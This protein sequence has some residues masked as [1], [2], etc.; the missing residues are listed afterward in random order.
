M[1]RVV[2][3]ERN[4]FTMGMYANL[5]YRLGDKEDALKWMDRSVEL[6]HEEEIPIYQGMYEKMKRGEKT[7]E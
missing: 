7:W 2:E 5:L 6:A 4:T 1:E 3:M